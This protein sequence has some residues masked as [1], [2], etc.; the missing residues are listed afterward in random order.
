MTLPGGN[1]CEVLLDAGVTQC[2]GLAG[3][4]GDPIHGC[5]YVVLVDTA[6]DRH[7]Q[8]AYAARLIR[9]LKLHRIGTFTMNGNRNRI[10]D[11]FTG[12]EIEG[13]LP[14]KIQLVRPDRARH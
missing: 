1:F 4:G 14:A 7:R 10:R 8:I 11:E 13:V 9:V 12:Y 3:R 2:L 6:G 5:G